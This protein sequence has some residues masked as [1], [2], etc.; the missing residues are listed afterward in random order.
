M[1]ADGGQSDL[2]EVFSLVADE[3][4]LQI[5]HALWEEHDLLRGDD[6]DPVSFSHLRETVGVRDSG[7]FHYHL[8]EL[9]PQLVTKEE[10]GYL[11]TYGG[12]QVVGAAVSGAYTA[13][14]TTL[15]EF[16]VQ[17][18]SRGDCDGTLTAEY[19]QGII[20]I[21]CNECIER[22]TFSAP[23]IL[24]AAHDPVADPDVFRSYTL[25]RLQKCF[26]GFCPNC[27]GPMESRVDE[28]HLDP[29]HEG[30]I[31]A[32]FECQ[33]CGAVS[34]TGTDTTLVGHPAVV[35]LFHDAGYDYRDIF[36]WRQHPEISATEAVVSVDPVR[37]EVRIEAGDDALVVEL[38]EELEVLEYER[39]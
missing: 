30:S 4:R 21:E 38:D 37:V 20:S 39:E 12:A 10:D 17:P 24:I 15:A 5:L 14:D 32:I 11:L 18:C 1:T 7:R 23:P 25:T 33:A 2:D 31:R 9:V 22:S 8:D 19:E 28:D 13:T 34:Q 6:V 35:S 29:D 27:M 36:H 3:T 16:D 26:R